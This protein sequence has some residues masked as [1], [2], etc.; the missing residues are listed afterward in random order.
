MKHNFFTLFFALVLQA[1]AA[2]GPGKKGSLLYFRDF[3]FSAKDR[4]VASDGANLVCEYTLAYHKRPT[5]VMDGDGGK[6][7]YLKITAPDKIEAGKTYTLN[8]GIFEARIA[9][10]GSPAYYQ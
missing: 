8:S 9:A 10:W 3:D 1:P 5:G 4:I 7:L 2:A 6:I